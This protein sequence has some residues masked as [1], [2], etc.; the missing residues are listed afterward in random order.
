MAISKLQ[1]KPS[2]HYAIFDDFDPEF[3][4]AFVQ[5][6]MSLLNTH[7]F[8]AKAIGF[9]EAIP[10]NNP[11][12]PVILISNHSGMAFPWD[13][14]VFKS[15]LLESFKYDSSKVCRTII[16]PALDRIGVMNPYFI[17][18]FWKKNGGVEA[19]FKNFEK[20]MHYPN[21]NV[22]IFPEGIDGISK[23]FDKRYQLQ[24]F[25]TSFIRMALKYKTD[26]VPFATINGEYLN[27]YSYNFKW[28]NK[29]VE[30]VSKIP[31]LPFGFPTIMLLIQPWFL[32]YALPAKLTYVKGKRISWKNL[33]HKKYEDLSEE[34]IKSIR[35]KVQEQAQN[36]LNTA[37]K[38]YGQ[39]PIQWRS[40]FKEFRQNLQLFPYL[41][42][43][44]WPLLFD[45]FYQQWKKGKPIEMRL[46][47]GSFLRIL[48]RNPFLITYFI[49]IIGWIPIIIRSLAN[50]TKQS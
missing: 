34:E 16:A 30:W 19:T 48:V 22:L 44:A 29:L 39:Q 2:L 21:A 33:T 40:F 6:V 17:K 45:E 43:F 12:T 15:L 36:E 38:E 31:R 50:S 3:A 13:A 26:I 41:L 35:D 20:M 46:G 25:A 1:D 8:R 9:E 32:Y 49:P 47:W 11:D 23:G 18:D 28:L 10:R 42:P 24:R 5:H 37:L 14:M 4:K 7:Y 27:P